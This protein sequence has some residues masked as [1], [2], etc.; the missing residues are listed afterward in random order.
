MNKIQ[1]TH[2]HTQILI[3]CSQVKLGIKV[4]IIKSV[5]EKTYYAQQK[6]DV[7]LTVGQHRKTETQ[8]RRRTPSLRS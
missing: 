5:W 3:Q 6:Q 7:T 8:E 4:L 2:T 1:N